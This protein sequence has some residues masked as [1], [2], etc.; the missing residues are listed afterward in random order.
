M[1]S[2]GQIPVVSGSPYTN[3]YAKISIKSDIIGTPP[4]KVLTKNNKY[5]HAAS[6]PRG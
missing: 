2:Y 3:F 5:K 4:L 6:S 1:F